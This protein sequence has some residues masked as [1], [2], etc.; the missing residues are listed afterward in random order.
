MLAMRKTISF[1]WLIIFASFVAADEVLFTFKDINTK[2]NIS[3]VVVYAVFEN[4]TTQFVEKDG[5]LNLDISP[6]HEIAF[7]VDD[8]STKG[9]DYFGTTVSQTNMASQTVFLF[10][11]GT[12]RGIVKDA[13]DNIV[14]SASL[15]FDCR[16]IPGTKFPDKT[17]RFGS[18]SVE[19]MPAGAC[20]IYATY[21]NGVGVKDVDIERG[22]LK[23]IEL[24]LDK[25]IV[26]QPRTPIYGFI[27]L[28]VI[29]LIALIWLFLK[30]KI[31][32][33]QER[34]HRAEVAVGKRSQDILKTL[35]P[36]ERD[37]VSYLLA[38]K[39]HATQASIRHNT[40]IPR[41]SLARVLQS[42]EA[43]KI[44]KIS[45]FGKAVK[46]QLTDWFL[47]KE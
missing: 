22:D 24:R 12:V 4:S 37:V 35:N 20:K 27:I 25:T 15:K 40:G 8:L 44:I 1:I 33:P 19:A 6:G 3:D 31:K 30:T 14:G 32:V 16:G 29:V 9:Q 46:V 28:L 36:K 21:L 2:Q 34:V 23:N 10:P 5:G 11:I 38:N 17:D 13:L 47:E 39:G 18:F 41:T 26:T 43:K 42:L 45:K 7:L